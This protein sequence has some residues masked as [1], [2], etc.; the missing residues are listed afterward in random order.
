MKT[1]HGLAV[2]A[3]A[4]ACASSQAATTGTVTLELDNGGRKVVSEL[5]FAAAEGAKVVDF[6]PR[7]PLRAVSIARGAAPAPS[8]SKRPLV[9]LSHG[10]WGTRFSQGWLAI[11][12]VNAGYIVL[13]T[14]HP[15]TSGDDQSAAG[16]LRMWDRARDVSFALSE[17]LKDPRWAAAIDASRIGFAGHSFGGST[18]V[19]LA[20]G[21]F[22]PQ[23]Q[24]AACEQMAPKDFYCDGTLKDDISGIPVVDAARSFK[25]ARFKAFYIMGSGPAAGFTAPSLKAIDAPFLVDTAR[26]D[27]ILE[28]KSNSAALA[29]QIPGAREINRP[30]GH[31]AYVPE[32]RPVIGALLASQICHDP[33]GV[34]RAV[35]HQQVARDAIDFFNR[36]LAQP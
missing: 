30:V 33:E 21:V 14:T 3:L 24:R 12:L 11:A 17:V 23:R 25:D 5:W 36:T 7:P 34:D 19:S 27:E 22:D 8:S 28:I 10:N 16:R 18:G 29:R 4:G 32:C 20:G 35:V 13:S 1:P 6:S 15:G 31:F 26:F 2:L 9:V